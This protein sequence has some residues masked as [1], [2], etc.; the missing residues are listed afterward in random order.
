MLSNI[1]YWAEEFRFDGFRFDGVTS[2][3]YYDHGLG[4]DFTGYGD[5]F[6]GTQDEDAL[7]YLGLANRLIHQ[8]NRGDYY[9]GRCKRYAFFGLSG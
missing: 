4:R 5:Y 3:I 7:V 1:K 2:M 6:D 9:S 8:S